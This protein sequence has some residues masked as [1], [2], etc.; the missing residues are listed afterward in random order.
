[1]T[2]TFLRN[3]TEECPMLEEQLFL[4]TPFRF[5]V[6]DP[7]YPLWKFFHTSL[8][9]Q[10]SA[11]VYHKLAESR[12]PRKMGSTYQYGPRTNPD[13][14]KIVPNDAIRDRIQ[15]KRDRKNFERVNRQ[16]NSVDQVLIPVSISPN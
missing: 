6:I 11:Q 10:L 7:S 13:P 12:V 3:K 4:A 2:W 9:P 15:A 1:M 16:E 8:H 14:N 5:D